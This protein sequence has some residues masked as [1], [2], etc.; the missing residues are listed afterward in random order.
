VCF[1]QIV[2]LYLEIV[3]T[4]WLFFFFISFSLMKKYRNL[5]Y[6]NI[7]NVCHISPDIQ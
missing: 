7:Y 5:L 6:K 4:V 1:L 2:I 3:L